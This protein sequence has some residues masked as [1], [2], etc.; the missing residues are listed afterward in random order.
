[1]L[2]IR[3]RERAI[4]AATIPGRFVQMLAAELG[5]TADAVSTYLRNPPAMVSS[6]SFR[7]NV[8]PAITAQISFEEAVESSQLTPVQKK[9][10]QALRD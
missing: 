3:F 7:S 10:L 1:L 4:D 9:T 5:A 2:L 8:K 6:Q